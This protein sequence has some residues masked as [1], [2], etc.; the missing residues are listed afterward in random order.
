VLT[1]LRIYAGGAHGDDGALIDSILR[2]SHA[3]QTL[4]LS[5]PICDLEGCRIKGITWNYTF[6]SLQTLNLTTYNSDD[7]ALSNFLLRCPRIHTLEWSVGSDYGFIFPQDSLRALSDLRI[8]DDIFWYDFEANFE[9]LANSSPLLEH[10]ETGHLEIANYLQISKL[11]RS[12][13]SLQ[14]N[15]GVCNWRKGFVEPGENSNDEWNK[16]HDWEVEE[17]EAETGMRQLSQII[18]KMLAGLPQLE[19][20]DVG[21]ETAHTSIDGAIPEPLDDK[22]LVRCTLS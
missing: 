1:S 4:Y 13:K 5:F 22:D 17:L 8:Y 10:L 14:L 19:E 11:G 20:L 16:H 2:S 12:L 21:L 9:A 18:T 15:P 7:T 6:P 3:L